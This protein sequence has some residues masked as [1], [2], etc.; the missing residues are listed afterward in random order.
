M[1]T[2]STSA[3]LLPLTLCA[4]VALDPDFGSAG[5]AYTSMEGQDELGY[6]VALR[7]DGSV[8]AVGTTSDPNTSVF[9]ALISAF[10]ETGDPVSGFGSAGNV[11]LQAGVNHTWWNA[12]AVAA[13]DGIL[14]AGEAEWH[15]MLGRYLPTGE[16]DPS[17]DGDGLLVLSTQAACNVHDVLVQPDGM[18]L[19][20]GATTVGSELN[21]CL[22]RFHPDGTPDEAFGTNGMVNTDLPGALERYRSI[23]VQADGGIVAAGSLGNVPVDQG[24]CLARYYSD[25]TLDTSFNGDG[26]YTHD[27]GAQSEAFYD[28]TILGNGN[29]L[30]GGFSGSTTGFTVMRFLPDGTPDAAF[31]GDGTAHTTLGSAAFGHALAVQAD[32]KVLM[33]GNRNTGGVPRYAIARFNSDGSLD[34]TFNGNGYVATPV[35]GNDGEA[36]AMVLDD[37]GR[38]LLA[39]SDKPAGSYDLVVAR[40]VNNMPIGMAELS[41]AQVLP[42][43]FPVPATCG[44][45]V[46]MALGGLRPG[47]SCQVQLFAADGRLLRSTIVRPLSAD[48]LELGVLDLPPGL[49]SATVRRSA[50]PSAA[51]ARFIL[52]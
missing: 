2:V 18:I 50:N 29:I 20:A 33:A 9:S 47:E 28:V 19:V 17:L 13:D 10:T 40:Y 41:G 5:M 48:R 51:R 27:A 31:D 24:F 45:T 42:Q 34:N 37:Q 39:G 44:T 36:D 8:V 3:L 12:V 52:E 16:P 4:Q 32:G 26:L 6:A 35:P 49:Y 11:V 25:G 14:V 46:C 22:W 23:A 1:R 15:L 38:M 21:A 7:P 43:C 30:A